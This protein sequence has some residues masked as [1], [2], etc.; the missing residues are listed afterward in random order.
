[1][2]DPVKLIYKYKNLNKRSQYQLF[3]YIGYLLDDSTKKI[4]LKIK[5]LNFYDTLMELS[6]KE[7]DHLIKIYGEKW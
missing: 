7:I 6:L 4:L 5:T 1:M 3:I 2:D